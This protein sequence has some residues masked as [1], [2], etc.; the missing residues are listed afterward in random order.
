MNVQGLVT[1][2]FVAIVVQFGA[3]RM[4]LDCSVTRKYG[5]VLRTTVA[6]LV[7]LEMLAGVII[8]SQSSS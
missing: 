7:A 1:G 5:V 3:G 4:G 6:E 2:V 8:F